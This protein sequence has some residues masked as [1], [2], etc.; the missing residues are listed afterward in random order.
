MMGSSHFWSY[1]HL[2]AVIE[3]KVDIICSKKIIIRGGS[4]E[5]SSSEMH[6]IPSIV[7]ILCGLFCLD[8]SASVY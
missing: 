5:R 2:S 3:D 1:N 4:H 8:G 6:L 7:E